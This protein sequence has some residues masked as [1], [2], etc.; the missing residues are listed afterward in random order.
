MQEGRQN[1]TLAYGVLHLESRRFEFT[2]AGHPPLLYL[3]S[4]REPLD[5]LIGCLMSEL[6]DWRGDAA[7]IEDMSILA[8]D[9]S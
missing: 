3:Q 7:A 9:V 1:F 6:R 2:S 5:G 4:G 8:F